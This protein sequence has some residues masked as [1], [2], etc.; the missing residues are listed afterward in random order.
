MKPSRKP[1]ETEE[2]IKVKVLCLFHNDG[3]I[4]ASRGLNKITN[5]VFYRLLGGS[6]DFFETAEVGIRREIDEELHSKIENLRFIEVTENIF[7]HEDWRGH[8]IIFLYSGNLARKELYD[9][10]RIH[11]V[12]DT[13]E[14]D[15]EWIAITDILNGTRTLFPALDWEKLF[16]MLVR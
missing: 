1:Q 10:Q 12:E 5:Q 2:R 13:Y 15:A 8:E 11:I 16:A 3:K 14:F 6:L 7:S 9:Q 4:L